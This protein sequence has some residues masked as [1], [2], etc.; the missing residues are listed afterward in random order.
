MD[1][2]PTLQHNW[3]FHRSIYRSPMA[4]QLGYSSTSSSPLRIMN[5]LLNG[6]LGMISRILSGK[7]QWNSQFPKLYG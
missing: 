6:V 4:F 7:I 5:N 2:S 3:Q 1:L